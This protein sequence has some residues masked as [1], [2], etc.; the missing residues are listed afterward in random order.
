[1]IDHYRRA[2]T[3]LRLTFIGAPL[4]MMATAVACS[5][6]A[7]SPTP[8]ID[9]PDGW[10]REE[11]RSGLIG[12]DIEYWDLGFTID[13]PAG[14]IVEEVWPNDDHPTGVLIGD[15]DS[16]RSAKQQ[17]FYVIGVESEVERRSLSQDPGYRIWQ[18]AREEN[19]F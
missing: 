18:E 6:G 13:L 11:A 5:S 2:L 10:R 17:L 8:D 3:E 4:A 14:W 16:D 1:M 7:V 9:V 15:Q 12:R 19:G